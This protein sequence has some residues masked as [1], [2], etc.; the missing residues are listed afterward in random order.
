LTT[1][2][3]L[4]ITPHNREERRE[5]S[6]V[7]EVVLHVIVSTS[8]QAQVMRRTSMMSTRIQRAGASPEAAELSDDA[9]LPESSASG[10]GAGRGAMVARFTLMKNRKDGASTL[11]AL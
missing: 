5:Q 1:L 4:R 6:F 9:P 11:G 3:R 8:L 10:V 7:G 2:A